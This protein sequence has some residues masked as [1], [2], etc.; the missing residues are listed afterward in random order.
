MSTLQFRITN[1]SGI[2]NDKVFIGFWGPVLNATINGA[3]MRSIEDS[4]WYKLSEIETFVIGVTTSGRIYVAYNNSFSPVGGGM[5]SI[6][7]PNSLAYH[8][9][10]DLFELTFDGTPYGV[11]D[12][13]AI[14]AWSIPMSLETEKDGQKVGSLDGVKAGRTLNEIYTNLS[15]LSNPA[16]SIATGKAII[17]AFAAAGNPLA[18]GIQ[19]QLNKPAPGLVTDNNNFVRIIGPNSYPP[20]GDPANNIPPGLP[21]TPYN[22][23]MEYLLYLINTFGPGKAAPPGFSQLGGGKIAHLAGEYGGSTA[24]SGGPYEQQSYDLWASIDDNFNLAINGTGSVVGDIEIAITKWNLLN[25]AATYGGNPQFSLNGGAPQS[26]QNNLYAWIL[27]DF[28]AGLNIGAIGSSVKVGGTVVGEMTS[29]EWFSKLPQSGDLFDKLWDS[30][31]TNYWN[32]WAQALN[33]R[34]DA[35]NFAYAERFSAPQLSINP[36]VVD[37]LTLILL[38]ADV[39]SSSM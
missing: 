33:S 25:P 16:Q 2:S 36:N 12:L 26:P 6:V 38:D 9:R 4:T 21:F 27:G 39:T 31:V 19:D 20:F 34:S 37:T 29:S 23:F 10:F 5:P 3:P 11:A 35:Y 8:T 22:T 1:N 14:D 7:A 28:F 13:T 24:G 15:N 17:K 32:Q 18:Q 30:N